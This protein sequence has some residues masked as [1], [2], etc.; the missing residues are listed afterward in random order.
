[1]D[2]R[3]A[4]W[5]AVAL[6][7]RRL[8]A[9]GAFASAGPVMLLVAFVLVS[10][11]H[12][13]LTESRRSGGIKSTLWVGGAYAR[14]DTACPARLAL[15]AEA[16]GRPGRHKSV[17]SPGC[18]MVRRLTEDPVASVACEAIRTLRPAAAS[19]TASP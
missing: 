8:R 16:T 5:G 3:A 7:S 11:S 1:M 14:L 9:L 13:R 4:V 6:G 17:D 18:H 19:P 15:P 10:P 12:R 2:G